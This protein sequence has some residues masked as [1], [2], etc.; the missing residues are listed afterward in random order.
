MSYSGFYNLFFNFR[1]QTANALKSLWYFRPSRIYLALA[2][3]WQI[4]AWF[5]AI[6][7]FKN[8]SSDLLVLHYNI[9]YG[10]DLVSEPN[11]IFYYPIGLLLALFL[12]LIISLSLYRHKDFKL[13]VNLLLGALALF[14]I[15]LNLALLS[16]YLINFR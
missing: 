5:Q 7:I 15:F 1:Q 9:D 10:T 6:Y 14:S 2:I 11:R 13:F 4:L 3:F 8:L 12:N 16:I